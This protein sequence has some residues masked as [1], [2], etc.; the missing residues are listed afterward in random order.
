MKISLIGLF[1][2]IT[3]S[4]E[5]QS[6]EVRVC[7]SILDS[8]YKFTANTNYDILLGS[9]S[10]SD[11][12]VAYPCFVDG[13]LTDEIVVGCIVVDFYNSFFFLRELLRV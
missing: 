6:D 5:V 9:L 13:N 1:P 4:K 12:K 8:F 2:D 10:N 11:V 3:F 7:I